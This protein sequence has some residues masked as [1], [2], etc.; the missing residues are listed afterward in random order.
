MAEATYPF[1]SLSFTLVEGASARA[2]LRMARREDGMYDLHVERGSAVNPSS[3]FTRAVP[4]E[5]AQSL[6]DALQRA[7]VF[8]WDESY[9]DDPSATARRWVLSIVFREDVF[10]L[11]SRGGSAVPTG[12]GE[13]L[14]ELYR[15]D[16]PRPDARNSARLGASGG[17]GD[18]DASAQQGA[19]FGAVSNLMGSLGMGGVGNMSA[20]DLGAYGAMGKGGFGGV[21]FSEL[22]NMMQDGQMA[23]LFAEMQSNP[24]AF[25]Q[26]MKDEFAHMSPAEQN[27]L[28]DQLAA[29]GM[30]SRAWWE[31]F[32]RGY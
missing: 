17:L 8:G 31:R 32:L 19:G 22:A 4:I 3:Q 6:N 5:T 15:L 24:R 9:G 7:G 16:F 26:R 25:E 18:S 2:A 20:G 30:A 29:T 28:L 1:H 11:S 27:Q 13:L 21:D 23:D 14:E 10:T 12:F